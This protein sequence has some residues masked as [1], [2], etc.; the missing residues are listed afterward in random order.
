VV[1]SWPKWA[2]PARLLEPLAAAA[3]GTSYM[4]VWLRL[5]SDSGTGLALAVLSGCMVGSLPWVCAQGAAMCGLMVCG[6]GL[7]VGGSGLMVCGS[8]L[9][10]CGS[11]AGASPC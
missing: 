4:E 9:M 6:F 2:V 11:P 8:G 7:M 10:V 5:K 3:G 1:P